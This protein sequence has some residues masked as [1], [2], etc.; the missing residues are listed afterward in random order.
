MKPELNE[1]KMKTI[2]ICDKC[3]KE[4]ETEITAYIHERQCIDGMDMKKAILICEEEF[5]DPYGQVV[6]KQCD[7]HY[8]VYG[9]EL[10]CK[11]ERSCKK[12]DNYPFWKEEEK[13]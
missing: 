13:K 4:F 11:Y 3:G 2:Y 10:S 1:V 12:R 9:C 7:N 5:T 6:C 8:M